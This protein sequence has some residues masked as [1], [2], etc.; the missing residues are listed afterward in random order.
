M[1]V[2]AIDGPSGSGK[3]TVAKI[4]SEKLGFEYINSGLIYRAITFVVV[5]EDK[6]RYDDEKFVGSVINNHEFKYEKDSVM[7]D[8]QYNDE[9]RSEELTVFLPLITSMKAVR[10]CVNKII[11][12]YASSHAIVIDGRD[13]GTVVFPDAKTKIYLDA[14]PKIRAQ[15]RFDET[16]D[17]SLTFELIYERLLK[18]DEL[19]MNRDIAPLVCAEDA[20][21]IDSTS[22]T[23]DEVVNLIIEK[24]E[25]VK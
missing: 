7:I 17:E 14:D 16:D 22:Y 6:S 8:G 19:D 11:R 9:C 1:N 5:N 15:R 12:E 20:Y 4:V 2:I 3:S 13:I 18:R 23:I 10:N 21:V 24:Y 25:E